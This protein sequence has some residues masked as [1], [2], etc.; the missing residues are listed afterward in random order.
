[1]YGPGLTQWNLRDT[2]ARSSSARRCSTD[3]RDG[4]CNL[5]GTLGVSCEP[6]PEGE[7]D[8]CL[9]LWID[10]LVG[11]LLEDGVLVDRTGAAIDVD[12]ACSVP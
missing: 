4:F 3:G 11:H 10:G 7:P 12:P 2:S 9:P 1:L 5:A 8:H 6:C